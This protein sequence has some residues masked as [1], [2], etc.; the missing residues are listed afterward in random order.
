MASAAV[1]IPNM[2]EAIRDGTVP[3]SLSH[4]RTTFAFPRLAY[5]GTRG[6]THYWTIRVRLI[7]NGDTGGYVPIA[8]DMLDQPAADLEGRRA[9]ITVEARQKGGKVRDIMPTYVGTGKN[10]GR[11]N[12]TNALTQALRDALGLYNK[13]KKRA[14]IVVDES[15]EEGEATA[16]G[17]NARDGEPDGE[18]HDNGALD[19]DFDPLP[20]PMLVKKLGASREATLTEADF[21][22]GITLQRKFNGVHF[23]TFERTGARGAKKA[24]FYS[25]TGTE[26]PGQGHVATE[27]LPMLAAPPPVPPGEYGTPATAATAQ[28]R[29]I[30]AAYRDPTP[31]F[32]GELYLFGKSLPWISGQARRGDD[33]GLLQFHV[34]DVF[35][36]YAKA[37]GHDMES[38]YRQAYIDAFFAKADAEGLAHPHVVRVENFHPKSAE[39][40]TRLAKG[41]VNA[42]YEG[43]IARKDRAGYR[44][45][46]SAYHSANLVKIKPEYDA[47]FPVVG[48]TQGTRGKDVGAVVWICEVPDPVD[49]RDKVFNVVPKDM[50]Y[51]VR[52]KL[53]AALGSKVKDASGR[54]V[55]RF[56]RD[57]K[58]LPL[59]VS[60]NELSPKTGKPLQAKAVTFRT[61]EEGPDKDPYRKL[62]ADFGISA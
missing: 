3:G 23:V 30:L 53:F 19:G 60:Y 5:T 51:E 20:P 58:G 16:E 62:L 21:A 10:L 48:Y 54:T 24:V 6:A 14:D 12:A 18:E 49:P 4:D 56:E 22:D 38:R 55:T 1:H 32:D 44:Y 40:M 11:R 27:M 29:R 41:F 57:I 7:D 45:S 61:Y 31:Y 47:E 43:G 17:E 2:L 15:D 39:E 42:G 36:P 13:Q 34:F 8:D 50:T 9:E 28:D 52:R 26:F 35:F 33:A 37:A 59:T 25:R 46:Y